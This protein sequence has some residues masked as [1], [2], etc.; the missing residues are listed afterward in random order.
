MKKQYDDD[1]GRTIVSMDV[2]GMPWHDRRVRRERKAA[3]NAPGQAEPG[4]VLTKRQT[5]RWIFRS[6]LA[7]F[8]VI[9]VIGGGLVLLILIEWL[10][11]RAKK[12]G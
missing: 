6:L 12:G 7:A 3:E 9:A 5:A 2:E 11:W 8:A 10:V 1:D 4:E